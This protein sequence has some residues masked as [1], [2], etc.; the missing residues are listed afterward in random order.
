[1]KSYHDLKI[2]LFVLLLSIFSLTLILSSA[3][4]Q[5]N[6]T[7]EDLYPG[8]ASDSLQWATTAKLPKGT[9]L[10]A[11]DLS[12][13]AS[14]LSRAIRQ[15][16]PAV[17][18]QLANNAFFLLETMATKRLLLQEARKAG[19]KIS[20]DEDQLIMNFVS[21]KIKIVAVSEEELKQFYAQNKEMIGGASWE[22]IREGLK[23]YLAQQKKQEAIQR[24]I[25]TLGQRTAIRLN[26][27]WV[28]K[29]S[30]LTLDNPVDRSRRSGNPTMVEFGATGCVPCDMMTPILADLKKKFPGKLNVLFVHVGQETILGARFGI[31]SIPVQVFFDQNGREVFRHT[32]FFPQAELE[33]KL[34]QLG[35]IN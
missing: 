32:G 22:K 20:G 19:H 11:D 31:Q 12:I 23:T 8:L 9:L 16:E 14:E 1:M 3:Q 5:T 26:Q 10:T 13:K 21:E 34:A 7:V 18:K 29:Q 6:K 25:Q 27:D 33:R 35:L 30:L 15:S 2:P 4:G 28:K 17:R 24:Y